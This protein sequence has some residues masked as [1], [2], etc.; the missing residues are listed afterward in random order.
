MSGHEDGIL[1]QAGCGQHEKEWENLHSLSFD[2]YHHRRHVLY[3][4]I[5]VPQSGSGGDGRRRYLEPEPAS[6][7]LDHCVVCADFFV[8]YQQLSDE[9]AEK[10]IWNFSGAGD[11]KTTLVPGGLVGDRLCGCLQFDSRFDSGHCSGQGDVSDKDILYLI[12]CVSDLYSDTKWLN[13]R[14]DAIRHK[15]VGDINDALIAENQALSLAKNAEMP[16]WIIANILIDCRNFEN[17]IFAIERKP[18]YNG[19]GQ[20][21]LDELNTIVYLPVL[22][23]YV[24]NIFET[25]ANETKWLN[26]EQYLWELVLLVLSM[27]WKTIFL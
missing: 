6:G 20:K 8:L 22:D 11:G 15:I 1:C 19:K 7:L 26:L 23:R 4:H 25:L 5:T 16:P 27:M 14:W 17:E 10:R 12:N 3:G 9:T 13:R 24:S 18:F 2:L 21:E